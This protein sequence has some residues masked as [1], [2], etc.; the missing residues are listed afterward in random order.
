M[1]FQV[2]FS[3]IPYYSLVGTPKL[4]MQSYNSGLSAVGDEKDAVMSAGSRGRVG[5]MS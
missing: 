3:R 4:Y 5:G 2:L 1:M